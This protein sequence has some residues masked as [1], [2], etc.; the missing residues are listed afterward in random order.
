[1]R[2][3][4]CRWSFML[5]KRAARDARAYNADVRSFAFVGMVVQAQ[6]E[7][8]ERQSASCCDPSDSTQGQTH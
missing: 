8:I 1:M 5:D 2:N 6:Q 7:C 4:L 3:L